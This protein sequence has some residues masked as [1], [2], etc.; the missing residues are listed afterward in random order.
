M[1]SRTVGD[2]GSAISEGHLREEDLFSKLT[3]K[4]RL[5]YL[6]WGRNERQTETTCGGLLPDVSL[7][8]KRS[9]GETKVR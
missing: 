9:R 4:I 8:Q 2:L 1:I 6:S 5:L 7:F 3:T